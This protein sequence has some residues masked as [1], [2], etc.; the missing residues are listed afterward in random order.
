M[1][2]PNGN[3]D[4][5][6]SDNRAWMLGST[7]MD[8]AAGTQARERLLRWMDESR[9]V[10]SL[11]AVL[12][13]SSQRVTSRLHHSEHETEV[14]RKELHELRKEISELRDETGEQQRAAGDTQNQLAEL[15]KQNETLRQE[16]EEAA[17]AFA[18]L[19]ETFQ[20]TNQ[21]AQKLGVTKSPFAR[22]PAA[23]PPAPAQPE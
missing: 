22:T 9:E 18:R 17:Q 1:A 10:L 5:K 14:L 8:D 6:I 3:T 13:E 21:I 12:V 16:K 15:R 23:T 7:T 19:L 20:S 4:A 11:L 2:A